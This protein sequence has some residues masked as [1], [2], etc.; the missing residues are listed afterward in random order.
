MAGCVSWAAGSLYTR[1]AD[2]PASP[3]LAAGMQMMLGGA[4]LLGVSLFSGEWADGGLTAV[5]LRSVAAIT[6]L[7]VI[8]S[9]IAFTAYMYLLRTVTPE[10]ASTY[11]YV[12]PIIAVLLGVTLGNEPFTLSIALSGVVI[13]GSVIL[14]MSRPVAPA[15]GR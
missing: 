7:V 4:L 6:Y 15:A 9:L 5:S 8:G 12:N 14:M 10:R 13:I 3:I 11:A 2:L 1:T